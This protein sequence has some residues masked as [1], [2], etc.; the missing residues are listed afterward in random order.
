[1]AIKNGKRVCI[2]EIMPVGVLRH[3]LKNV[4]LAELDS[5][6]Y[7]RGNI[8]LRTNKTIAHALKTPTFKDYSISQGMLRDLDEK[9]TLTDK[10]DF[11]NNRNRTRKVGMFIIFSTKNGATDYLMTNWLSEKLVGQKNVL[12]AAR[13]ITNIRLWM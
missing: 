13:A 8:Y 7:C 9:G 3:N 6:G 11:E 1:M 10:L 4:W 12:A 2:V 5:K